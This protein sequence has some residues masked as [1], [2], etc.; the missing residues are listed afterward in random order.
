M[1]LY[2]ALVQESVVIYSYIGWNLRKKNEY[3]VL[4]IEMVY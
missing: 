3:P 4:K 2:E 1:I